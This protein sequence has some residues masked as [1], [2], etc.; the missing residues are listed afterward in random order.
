VIVL[1]LFYSAWVPEWM[2]Q[3]PFSVSVVFLCLEASLYRFVGY[4]NEKV[5]DEVLDLPREPIRDRYQLLSSKF[6]TISLLFLCQFTL[7]LFYIYALNNK[8]DGWSNTSGW[9][10]FI[11]VLLVN[12]AGEEEV[13]N[14]F[15]FRFWLQLVRTTNPRMDNTTTFCCCC[16]FK[17][18]TEAI[19]R[20]I[21]SMIV[22]MFIRRII[23]CTAPIFLATSESP[24]DFIKDCLAV[25]FITKLDE[26][27][28]PVA[29]K[30][31]L[32]KKFKLNNITV[33]KGFKNFVWE[34]LELGEDD[35]DDSEVL[36][37]MKEFTELKN[38][39]ESLEQAA[40][41]RLASERL[42]R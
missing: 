21:M 10:W 40:S 42:A 25:F 36:V 38:R 5:T 17:Y 1:N 26:L 16:P 15:S 34:P 11:S 8:T 20:G 19:I 2:Y 39:V 41:E 35:G 7:G 13:G 18:R 6:T 22:N 32:A 24:I 31:D 28:N 37:T 33:W 30:D 4:R 12:L 14:S 9:R 29:L 23:F 3:N 27:D